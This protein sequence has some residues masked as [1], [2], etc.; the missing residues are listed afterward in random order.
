MTSAHNVEPNRT[1]VLWWLGR[2][3][4]WGAILA[5]TAV[6]ALAVLVPRLGGA[7]PYA[8][9]T[10]SMEPGLPPGTLIVARPVAADDI[11]VGSV[12]TYQLISGEQ[13]VVTHRVVGV[14]V[15]PAG[16]RTFRTQGD[17]NSAVDAKA[18]RP[19]QIQ[20]ELWYSVPQLGYVNKYLSGEQ[21]YVAA[22]V[23]AALLLI[24]AVVMFVGAIRDRRRKRGSIEPVDVVATTADQSDDVYVPRHVATRRGSR[25]LRRQHRRG[26]R[27][28]AALSL[29]LV[30]GFGALS[31]MAY[32]SDTGTATGGTFT[33]GVLDMK[34]NGADSA[35]LSSTLLLDT[36]VPGESVAAHL[37]VQNSAP[38]NVPFTYTATGLASGALNPYL[39]FEVFLGGTSSNGTS[40]G[41][42]TGTCGGTSTGATQT[43]ATTKTV[44]GTPQTVAVSGSQNVCVVA[45]L[46]TST[47]SNMQGTTGSAVFTFTAAQIG[48]P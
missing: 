3:V 12:I 8:V 25:R 16:E 41:L 31:T 14:G 1:G 27:L 45:L 47:P 30:G 39:S 19:V 37:A 17:A 20:G 36:M 44:I 38:S 15:N 26:R 42:R 22:I 6:I 35:D 29:G 21:S 43:M 46:L 33:A 13:T 18:V 10:S 5:T 40:G 34:L 23:V 48:A 24:Y 4:A 11:S 28:R 9:L 2:V 7:T 32:W